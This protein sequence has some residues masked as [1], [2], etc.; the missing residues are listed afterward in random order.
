MKIKLSFTVD[1][2]YLSSSLDVK[3]YFVVGS[4]GVSGEMF[5]PH[6][7]PS[8][9][10]DVKSPLTLGR[11]ETEETFIFVDLIT[12][13]GGLHSVQVVLNDFHFFSANKIFLRPVT[14]KIF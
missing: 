14:H 9:E 2:S 13:P 5:E 6:T 10:A 3:E 4:A 8:V 1:F 7:N 12:W 11:V